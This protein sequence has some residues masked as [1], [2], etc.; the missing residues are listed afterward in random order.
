MHVKEKVR[1]AIGPVNKGFNKLYC[2]MVRGR[3]CMNAL[4]YILYMK[5]YTT[6]EGK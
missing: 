3:N 4:L 2:S 1:I 6:V 5:T